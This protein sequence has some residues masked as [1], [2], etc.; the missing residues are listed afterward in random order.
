MDEQFTPLSERMCKL[1]SLPNA[2]A[3]LD[4]KIL[5]QYI[6]SRANQFRAQLLRQGAHKVLL[7]CDAYLPSVVMIGQEGS[8][9][10]VTSRS[11]GSESKGELD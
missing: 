11:T 5:A 8:L 3:A 1:Y 4:A 10:I 9:P 2:R 7:T 6:R